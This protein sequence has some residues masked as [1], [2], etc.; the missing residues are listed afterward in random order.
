M[1]RIMCFAARKLKIETYVLQHGFIDSQNGY[2]PLIADKIFCWSNYERKFFADSGVSADRLLVT[3]SPRFENGHWLKE[4]KGIQAREQL[5]F[6]ICPGVPQDVYDQ[7]DIITAI[8]ENLPKPFEIVVRPHPYYKDIAISY[9]KAKK[10]QGDILLDEDPFLVSI[11]QSQLVVFGNVSTGVFEALSLDKSGFIL[12]GSNNKFD[13]YG[14]P[15]V[16][17]PVLLKGLA[18]GLS[19]IK[20]FDILSSPIADSTSFSEVNSSALIGAKLAASQQRFAEHI[21]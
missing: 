8:S 21:I 2:L 1:S 7:I 20:D 5:L 10:A 14:F 19:T 13:I 3:G 4:N 12:S 15:R 16:E 17:M 9:F 11:R 18:E 6:V